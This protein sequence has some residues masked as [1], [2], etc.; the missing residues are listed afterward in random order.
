MQQFYFT[1]SLSPRSKIIVFYQND[2]VYKQQFTCQF[3]YRKMKIFTILLFATFEARNIPAF[4][5]NHRDDNL[6]L[7]LLAYQN[8]T[9]IA[10]E[11]VERLW[12]ERTRSSSN[13]F[14]GAVYHLNTPYSISRA[15]HVQNHRN[16]K[17]SFLA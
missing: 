3:Q 17:V 14:L 5:E 13:G 10:N 2:V 9:S 6:R 7:K 11:N 16:L 15:A 4:D 8:A 12:K 1:F